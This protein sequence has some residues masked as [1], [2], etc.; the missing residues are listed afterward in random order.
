M[1]RRPKRKLIEKKGET[2]DPPT[3]LNE[4][5]IVLGVCIFMAAMVWFVFGQT[6]H[7][8]FV[9]L[10]DGAYVYKNP[11]VSRGLTTEGIIWAFT[12]SHAA[13]WHPLTWLSHML[14]CQF[15]GLNPGGHHL[16]N[17]LLHT[18][19]AIL[20]FLVLRQMT[21]ALWRS[22]FV[23]AVFAIHPLRVESVAWVAERKDLLSGLFFILTIWAYVRYVRGPRSPARYLVVLA[24]FAVGL[25]C[26]PM[27]VTLPFVLLLL[28]YWPLCRMGP[29]DSGDKKFR[30]PREVI[31]DKLPLLGL[32]AASCVATIFAQQTALQPLGNISLPLRAGNAAMA[33]VTYIRQMFWPS[34]LAAFYPLAFRDITASRVLLSLVV[35]A[36]IS[37]V[38][39]LMRRRR[40]LVTGWLLYLIMLAP[41]IGILQVGSQAHADRYTYLPEIGLALLLTWTVSDL[42]ARW[43]YRRLF[44]SAL[45]LIIVFAL[46]FAARTQ[47]SYWKDSETLWIQALSRTSDN[48]MAELNLGEAVYKLGRTPEAIAHFER[49]LQIDPNQGWVYSSLGAALLEI[50]RPDASLVH[51]Q[52]AIELDPNS[53]DAHYNLGNT[54]LQMGRASEAVA[55][56]KRALEIAPDDT[57]TMNNMA[58]ILATSPDALVRDG[59]KAVQVAERADS[60]TRNASPIISATLAAAYAE[61]ARFPDAVR[62]A[63][64]AIQLA[65]NEG[66]KGRADSIRAQLSFYELGVPFRDRRF[67]SI[68]R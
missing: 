43:R 40:Y 58:W 36:G 64:R 23:A 5:W 62:T 54:F 8:Q 39:F 61:M 68:P 29:E 6:L 28:D 42:C 35:L 47:A 3:G 24:M 49:A 60:L 41:V 4:R 30:I 2:Q 22:A 1:S 66:N 11:Q 16:T 44:L 10:D 48:L 12:H 17:V 7:H 51:L 32:A 57:E 14:D 37:I 9:N 26:K 55:Q 45:S 46:T 53:S 18:A 65:L 20:L 21:G 13:N 67:G 27:L 15:Y 59:A 33:C 31:L 63:Q 38:V 56:Y 34:D 50:G 52:K 19:N 25:M